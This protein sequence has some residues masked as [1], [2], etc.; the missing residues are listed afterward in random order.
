MRTYHLGHVVRCS[1]QKDAGSHNDSEDEH[2][3]STA[4]LLADEEREDCPDE[5]SEIIDR[6][7]EALHGW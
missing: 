6:S 7:H 4:Q 5:A 1:L 2:G 3:P